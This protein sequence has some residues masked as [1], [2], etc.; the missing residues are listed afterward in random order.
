MET[1][2][3]AGAFVEMLNANRVQHI[4]FNPG[5]DTVPVQAALIGMQR[6]GKTTPSLIM[7]LDESVAMTAAQGHYMVSGRP[8]VVMVHAE[9]G[10][11]RVGG[12]MHNVQWG[13]VPVILWAGQSPP[14]QR[15]NWTKE[16]FDQSGIMRG[17]VK[18]D[19]MLSPT[20]NIPMLSCKRLPA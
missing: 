9:L 20:E 18:W 4:F 10:T 14:G 15:V 19:H 11:L 17:C 6:S 12:A 7:C 13:R 3:G 16:R 5:I 8:Q 1:Y 2:E